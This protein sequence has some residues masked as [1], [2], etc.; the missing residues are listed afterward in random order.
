MNIQI[1]RSEGSYNLCAPKEKQAHLQISGLPTSAPQRYLST[2]TDIDGEFDYLGDDFWEMLDCIE[3]Q[4]ES[5][6]IS[7]SREE[8]RKVINWI[9]ENRLALDVQI[10]HDLAVDLQKKAAKASE[11][12]RS[13]RHSYQC[14]LDDAL[15]AEAAPLTEK[16]KQTES[17]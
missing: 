9:R 3:G 10:R 12:A 13:A 15:D 14:A 17:A 4:I 11:A 5:L 6:W 7:T 16:P 2:T 8:Q 1:S